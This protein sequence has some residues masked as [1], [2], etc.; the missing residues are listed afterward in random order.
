MDLLPTVRS[1]VRR[2]RDEELSFVAASVAFYAFFSVIPLVLLAL[3]L[4]SLLGGESFE[5]L[6]L[7]FVGGYLS[8][9]GEVVVT[10]ALT[11][12]E[13]RLGASAV[14][15]VALAW[16]A[17]KVFRAVDVAFDSVYEVESTASLPERVFSAVVALTA[18]FV[19]AGLVVGLGIAVVRLN[20]VAP[21]AGFLGRL[22]LVGGL[23]VVFVP[24]YYVMPPVSVSLRETLPGTATAVVG[25]LLL[26]ALFGLYA[27]TAA[28]YQ[29][30]GLLGAV[31]LFLLWL[32]FGAMVLLTGAVVNAVV[33]EKT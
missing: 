20:A 10:E 8:A 17:L 5:A 7:S 11:S 15:F 30:Y 13:G 12:P 28:R 9:E 31:L 16:S 2:V 6:V 25:W 23:V 26:Q 32:Y 3:A 33:A 29:A 4:G 1:I 24:L 19:G 21:Y 27:S 22:V 18:I 14:G